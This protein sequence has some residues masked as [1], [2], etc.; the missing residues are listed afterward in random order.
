MSVYNLPSKHHILLIHYAF[1]Y[2]LHNVNEQEGGEG[3]RIEWRQA[4]ESTKSDDGRVVLS[5]LPDIV[6]RHDDSGKDGY[7]S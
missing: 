2:H 6:Q 4:N 7:D 5:D 3:T 1:Q